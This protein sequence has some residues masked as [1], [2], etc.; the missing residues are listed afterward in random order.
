MNKEIITPASD[1]EHGYLSLYEGSININLRLE[2][3]DRLRNIDL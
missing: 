3:K 2:F 1:N